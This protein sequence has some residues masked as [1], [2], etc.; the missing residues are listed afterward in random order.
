M[1]GNLIHKNASNYEFKE[2]DDL[3]DSRSILKQ[4]PSNNADKIIVHEFTREN[5]IPPFED[6][7]DHFAFRAEN[8]IKYDF[9][10]PKYFFSYHLTNLVHIQC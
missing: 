8:D 10:K 9:I 3:P 2:V 6:S 1:S 4:T 7:I 5:I